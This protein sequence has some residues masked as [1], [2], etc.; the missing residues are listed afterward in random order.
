MQYLYYGQ[1]LSFTFPKIYIVYLLSTLQIVHSNVWGSSS[2]SSN[3]G[4]KY[5]TLFLMIDLDFYGLTLCIPSP[6]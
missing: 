4:F 2:I 6:M 1:K 5:Y 3:Q